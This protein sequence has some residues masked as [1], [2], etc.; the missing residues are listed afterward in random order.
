MNRKNEF[1][2]EKLNGKDAWCAYCWESGE[3]NLEWNGRQE[4][5][6]MMYY[7]AAEARWVWYDGSGDFRSA[8]R[9][10]GYII[11]YGR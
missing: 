6:V 2:G 11:E 10:Y 3:P 4:T 1:Y 8:K 7:S 9:T 5:V